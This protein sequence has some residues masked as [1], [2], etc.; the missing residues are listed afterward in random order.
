MLAKT[1]KKQAVT[2]PTNS[3]KQNSMFER[4]PE[5]QVIIQYN[6]FTGEKIKEIPIG[7]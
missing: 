4:D 1:L 7:G 2:I 6:I 3:L 5:N